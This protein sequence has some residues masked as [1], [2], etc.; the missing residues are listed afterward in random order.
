MA[1]ICAL[2]RRALYRHILR[3]AND[4]AY[5][6]AMDGSSQSTWLYDVLCLFFLLPCLWNL[7]TTLILYKIT[8]LLL[9][10]LTPSIVLYLTVSLK[11]LFGLSLL[12]LSLT[13]LLLLHRHVWNTAHKQKERVCSRSSGLIF[14]L[15]HVIHMQFILW[16]RC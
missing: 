8:L 3:R 15:L 12:W 11:L 1:V 16:R 4:L 6:L 9:L 13:C 2:E 14:L 7:V 5:W 10:S